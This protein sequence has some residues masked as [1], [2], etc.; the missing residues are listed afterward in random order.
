METLKKYLLF[1]KLIMPYALQILFWA[2]IGGVLYGSWWLFTNDNW[3][4]IMSLVFGT[5]GTRLIFE[6]LLVRYQT[7]LTLREIKEILDA[8]S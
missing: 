6:A 2:A 7:Y 4:W 1:K 8:K 5:L 3:A